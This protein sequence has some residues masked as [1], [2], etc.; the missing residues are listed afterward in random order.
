MSFFFFMSRKA[1]KNVPI[2]CLSF[3]V[4]VLCSWLGFCVYHLPAGQGRNP[5]EELAD[6]Q[7]QSILKITSISVEKVAI[8]FES[9]V[10]LL[11]KSFSAIDKDK[12]IRQKLISRE[13]KKKKKKSTLR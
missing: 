4:R 5:L 1:T 12:R 11:E 9:I 2:I 10:Q 13:K 7:Q 8:S 6:R 3:Y